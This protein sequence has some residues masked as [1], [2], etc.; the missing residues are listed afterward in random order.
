MLYSIISWLPRYLF[1]ETSTAGIEEFPIHVTD[2]ITVP[3]YALD[4]LATKPFIKPE[5]YHIIYQWVRI[6]LQT[7]NEQIVSEALIRIEESAS[8]V[9]AGAGVEEF[10]VSQKAC[11]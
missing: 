6:G 9:P 7:D 8:T 1:P 2:K 10:T 4:I 11:C 5:E 3:K